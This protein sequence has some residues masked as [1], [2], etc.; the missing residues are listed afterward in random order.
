M[1]KQ[2]KMKKAILGLLLL[3]SGFGLV[4]ATAQ[5]S[6][7]SLLWE[8][9]GNGLKEPSYL[10]G[11]Y[12]L[13]SASFLDEKPAV[14]AVFKKSKGVVVEMVLDS[15]KLMQVASLSIMP[16]KKISDLISQEDF[17]LVSAALESATG[18][19]LQ[20][21]DQFK[22]MAVN[23]M[24]IG[25]YAQ[26]ESGHILSKYTGLPLDAHFAQAAKQEKRQVTALETMEEQIKLL[27]DFMP[28]EEQA[29]ELVN[30]VKQKEQMLK[31]QNDLL[32]AY[33]AEDFSGMVKQF[34]DYAE[35]GNSMGAHMLD[36][37]NMRW[38]DSIPGLMQG[39]SQ[40]IAVGALHLVGEKGL[41]TLLKQAGYQVK[42]ISTRL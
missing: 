16:G 23:V 9:S 21:L 29:K 31:S 27:Y 24:L 25:A 32:E 8:I 14:K 12:H 33:M 3:L 11:T 22:P 5:Q 7:N 15:S 6:Q 18:I 35:I 10:F 37:R 26:S 13:L 40:F 30:F 20:L 2:Q 1:R 28:Y 41:I 38:M 36:D 4:K 42:P 39:G 19:K 17:Q 34:E